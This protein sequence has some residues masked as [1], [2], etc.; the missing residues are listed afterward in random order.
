LNECHLISPNL[1]TGKYAI[2]W[3]HFDFD[4]YLS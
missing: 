3:A 1:Y 2:L 4:Q